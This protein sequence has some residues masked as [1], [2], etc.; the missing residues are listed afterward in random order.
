MMNDIQLRLILEPLILGDE[1]G[2][3]Y[4][5]GYQIKLFPMY[6]IEI[7]ECPCEFCL[8]YHVHFLECSMFMFIQHGHKY[9]HGEDIGMDMDRETDTNNNLSEN[10]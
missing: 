7:F 2:V 3:R 6:A 1:N 5:V 4:Y 8:C 10:C 9:G